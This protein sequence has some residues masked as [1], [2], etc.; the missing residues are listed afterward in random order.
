MAVDDQFVRHNFTAGG[1]RAPLAKGS[2]GQLMMK[3]HMPSAH[4][5]TADSTENRLQ[6]K[7]DSLL[8]IA[9]L[10]PNDFNIV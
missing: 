7:L 5:Y 4:E 2:S 6:T 9:L 10:K 8:E 1:W 3:T